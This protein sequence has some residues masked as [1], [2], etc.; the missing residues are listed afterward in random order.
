MDQ[1]ETNAKSAP[2]SDAT[3][4]SGQVAIYLEVL[5]KPAEQR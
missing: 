3:A 2:E 5:A 4:S 1:H